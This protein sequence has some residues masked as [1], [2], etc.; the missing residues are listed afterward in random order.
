[1]VDDIYKAAKVKL[2]PVPMFAFRDSTPT[3]WQ[4][5]L[6]IEGQRKDRRGLIA[7]IKRTL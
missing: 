2:E 4:H 7:G 5:H 3:M 6:I 1:M